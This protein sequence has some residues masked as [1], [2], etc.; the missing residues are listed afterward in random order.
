M[1]LLCLGPAFEAW[2]TALECKVHTTV[3]PYYTLS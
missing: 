2:C 1:R 3:V